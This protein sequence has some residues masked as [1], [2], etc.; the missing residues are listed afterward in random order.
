MSSLFN[1]YGYFIENIDG[2]FD[3]FNYIVWQILRTYT[4][5]FNIVLSYYTYNQLKW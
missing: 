1:V 4:G 3:F 2:A 5:S